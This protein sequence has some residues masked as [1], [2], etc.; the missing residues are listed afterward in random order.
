MSLLSELAP[1]IPAK[2]RGLDVAVY[3]NWPGFYAACPLSRALLIKHDALGNERLAPERD[4]AY[5]QQKFFG[6]D[7][8]GIVLSRDGLPVTGLTYSRTAPDTLDNS[9][10]IGM[11]AGHIG[12][13]PLFWDIGI[14]RLTYSILTRHAN[15]C[16][17]MDRLDAGLK[18]NRVV[19]PK[20]DGYTDY[21]VELTER[22]LPPEDPNEIPRSA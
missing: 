9:L 11:P 16:Q 7:G 5:Y 12:L 4:N 18:C 22:P 3:E 21:S 6:S 15:T 19:V 10:R 13:R 2:L 1:L 17:H 20:P 8:I 14:R